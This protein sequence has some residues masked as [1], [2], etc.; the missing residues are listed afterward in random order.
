MVARSRGP[1][2]IRE[3]PDPS[4]DDH[5]FVQ[6]PRNDPSHPYDIE[7]MADDTG[8]SLYPVEQKR[9]DAEFIVLAENHFDAL[10]AALGTALRVAEEARKEWDAA[11]TGMKAGKL[12]IA[13]SDPK[14]HYRADITEIHA[15]LTAVKAQ[16]EKASVGDS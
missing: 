11:P 12:L 2:R 3:H 1:W 16:Q 7:V 14:L 15:V 6:A 4:R 5:F 9:A 13:L 8:G 10:V